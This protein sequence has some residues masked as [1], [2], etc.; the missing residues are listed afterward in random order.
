MAA[1][2]PTTNA[3]SRCRLRVT[4]A[5]E[6]LETF[7]PAAVMESPVKTEFNVNNDHKSGLP[8]CIPSVILRQYMVKVC[9]LMQ[10]IAFQN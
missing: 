8:L 6:V 7:I 4:D 2:E 9:T 5:T 10:N 1:W 3:A